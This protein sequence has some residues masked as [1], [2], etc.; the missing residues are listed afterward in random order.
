MQSQ[1]KLFA[2]MK[3][4]ILF[5]VLLLVSMQVSPVH[6]VERIRVL[7]LF[8]DKAI[9]ELDGE[10]RLLYAGSTSPEG[11]TVIAATS[12]EVILEIE[13]QQKRYSLGSHIGNTYTKPATGTTVTI[14]PDGQ[15]MYLV[16]GS[17]NGFQVSFVVDT[18]ATFISM[19]R[20]QAARLGLRYKLD[21]R[22]SFVNTASGV[23]KIYLL[24][25][26]KVRVGD[27]ALS[28]IMAAVHDGD[29]PASILL[30]NSFLNR[31]ALQRQGR[32]LTLE[33]R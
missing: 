23:D 16:N 19:N 6:A 11:I 12:R 29:F 17:I 1:H 24:E 15:G 20:H 5:P 26:T 13:G 4:T 10:R 18:G 8:K 25:L 3:T 30:G 31:V 22:P 9:I 7:A 14:G 21:G 33:K 2:A 27:I 32:V 28:N